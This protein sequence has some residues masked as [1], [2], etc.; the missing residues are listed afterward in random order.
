VDLVIEFSDSSAVSVEVCR[1]VCVIFR[2]MNHL[3]VS[4]KVL[5]FFNSS[6]RSHLQATESAALKLQLFTSHWK[7]F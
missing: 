4:A 6:I 3:S 7:A 5:L 1:V 2:R